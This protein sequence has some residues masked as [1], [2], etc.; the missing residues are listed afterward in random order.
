MGLC[1]RRR[2]ALRLCTGLERRDPGYPAARDRLARGGGRAAVHRA[3]LGRALG[4]AA[5]QPLLDQLRPADVVVV[6]KRDRLSR[7]R[8]DLLHIMDRIAQ[9]EAG[10]RSLTEAI[11]TTT[12][13]GRMR[14]QMVG[15][16]AECERAMIRERTQAGFAIARAEGRTGGRRPKL[17]PQQQA[18]MVEMVR[19][20]RQTQAAA[21]RL[22]RVHPA[23][24]SRLVAMQQQAEPTTVHTPG[25]A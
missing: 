3:G 20:G 22:C 15:S 7:S 21:A 17:G 6:W 1:N 4:P 24:V 16:C 8:K 23:T 5:A 10:F 19:S 25:D 11:D 2:D 14:M 13:A 9:A 12:P 18:A